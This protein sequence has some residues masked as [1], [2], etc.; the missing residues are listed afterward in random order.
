MELI[1]KIEQIKDRYLKYNDWEDRY[2][3]LI[4]QGKELADF[5]PSWQTDKFIVKGCQSKVW[6]RP[7]LK[8]GNIILHADSDAVLVKGIVAV[9]VSVYSDSKPQDILNDSADFLK[10]IGITEHLSMNRTN[11]L[12]QMLKQIKLYAMAFDALVKKGIQNVDEL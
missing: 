5:D 8:N 3:E 2:R 7:S 4:T 6:L 10:E 12:A 11:G 9:L 1:E